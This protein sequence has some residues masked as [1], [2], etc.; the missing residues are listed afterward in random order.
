MTLDE[1]LARILQDDFN[2]VET[3]LE[4]KVIS[5]KKIKV[6]VPSLVNEEGK[7]LILRKVR[8]LEDIEINVGNNV[9]VEFINGDIEK[10]VIIGRMK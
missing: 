4:C 3:C 9:L 5:T 10:P 6:I 8:I 7:A 2:K 1:K